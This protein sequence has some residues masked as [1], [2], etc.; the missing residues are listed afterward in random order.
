M[1]VADK[2]DRDKAKLVAEER[3]PLLYNPEKS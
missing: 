1:N 2:L 3:Y